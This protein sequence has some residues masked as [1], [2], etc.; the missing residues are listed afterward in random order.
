MSSPASSV[1][2]AAPSA[3]SD[4]LSICTVDSETPLID[5]RL[6]A[7]PARVPTTTLWTRVKAVAGGFASF[8]VSA[9]DDVSIFTAD[10]CEAPDASEGAAQ[11][12]TNKPSSAWLVR[13]IPEM[14]AN[15]HIKKGS[16]Y[17]EEAFQLLENFGADMGPAL[18]RLMADHHEYVSICSMSHLRLANASI[19]CAK[20]GPNRNQAESLCVQRSQGSSCV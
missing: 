4:A 3:S 9:K 6:L 19:I 13:S 8:I 2:A 7:N 10:A 16:N 20:I 5:N 17:L 1:L 12:G 15:Y 11:I 14:N 18:E